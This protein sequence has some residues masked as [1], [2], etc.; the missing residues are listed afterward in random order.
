M[1]TH[2]SPDIYTL[3]P[4]ACG[5]RA[6]GVYIRQTTRAHGITIKYCS[7]ATS[8]ILYMH[9]YSWLASYSFYFNYQIMTYSLGEHVMID[10]IGQM[11]KWCMG[12]TSLLRPSKM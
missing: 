7:R 5:P 2:G 4:R 3:S 11:T 6:S 1:C 8:Y 9:A 12:S 10:R